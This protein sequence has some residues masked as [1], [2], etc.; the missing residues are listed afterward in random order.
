MEVFYQ[1]SLQIIVLLLTKTETATVSGLQTF[2]EQPSIF[3]IDSTTIVRYASVMTQSVHNTHI[4]NT[5]TVILS[6]HVNYRS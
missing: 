1:T 6:T 4:I 2:F 5:D 3:G